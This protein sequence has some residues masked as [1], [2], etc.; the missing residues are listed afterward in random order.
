MITPQIFKGLPVIGFFT[1]KFLGLSEIPRMLNIPLENIYLPIQR[2]TEKVIVLDYDTTPQIADAVVT[3]RRGILI[4]VQVADCVPIILY[5]KK[6]HIAGVIHSGW[7]GTAA[8]ILK[9]TIEKMVT[10]FYAN[11]SDI[12]I[13]IGPSIRWCCYGVG[14][15]V[16]D[17]VKKS[18][19]EGDYFIKKAD[20]YCL[21]L[22]TANKYQA[23][24]MGVFEQNIWLSDECT[25]C[26]QEK[27]YSYRFSKG[28]TGRQFGFIGLI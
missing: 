21:D 3:K 17:A 1:T 13:A 4:G 27:Y 23:L 26:H 24:S 8:G 12:I 28:V 15:E 16:I 18:T 20:K 6:M 5:E 7:R 19:G 9:K 25:F 10:Q 11:P 22:Q 2:H 14:Y